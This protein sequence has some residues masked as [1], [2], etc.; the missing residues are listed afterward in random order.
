[1]DVK[2]TT[3]TCPPYLHLKIWALVLVVQKKFYAKRYKP[4]HPA[5]PK[6]AILY[7][8]E[9]Q[10]STHCYFLGYFIRMRAH[11]ALKLCGRRLLSGE[12]NEGEGKGGGFLQSGPGQIYVMLYYRPLAA[13]TVAGNWLRQTAK[14]QPNQAWTREEGQALE[15]E[16]DSP[17]AKGLQTRHSR[18]AVPQPAAF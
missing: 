13:T 9:Q 10:G 15:Q 2:S 16:R 6:H 11:H 4:F 7:R 14:A 3:T 17:A 8:G 5:V 12:F 1:M 18:E